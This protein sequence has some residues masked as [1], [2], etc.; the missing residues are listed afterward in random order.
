[1]D[2]NKVEGG[3]IIVEIDK[4]DV[5]KEATNCIYEVIGRISYQKGDKPLSTPE[6]K[7]K[8]AELWKIPNFDIAHI[9]KGFTMF[10]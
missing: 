10:F 3:N 5:E 2:P 7:N 1:M 9:G 4:E 8:L 6:M